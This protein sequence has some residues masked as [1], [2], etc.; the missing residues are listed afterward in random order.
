MSYA[1]L[2]KAEITKARKADSIE[3][4]ISTRHPIRKILD[5][6]GLSDKKGALERA[7]LLI[8][9]EPVTSNEQ[10]KK[11]IEAFYW[12]R[13]GLEK[14]QYNADDIYLDIKCNQEKDPAT[15][16]FELKVKEGSNL[17]KAI[18]Q[19]AL[20]E[21][22]EQPAQ[23]SDSTPVHFGETTTL[24]REQFRRACVKL[25]SK[26]QSDF[27][28]PN[29]PELHAN[30]TTPLPLSKKEVDKYFTE[31]FQHLTELENLK[32]Y[33]RSVTRQESISE[34]GSSFTYI[35]DGKHTTWNSVITDMQ[36]DSLLKMSANFGV[37]KN[38]CNQLRSQENID[39]TNNIIAQWLNFLKPPVPLASIPLLS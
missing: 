12:L 19:A 18:K 10:L 7:F 20:D 31:C 4:L 1:G 21:P 9:A 25:K 6:I 34:D 3:T 5:F 15:V 8:S 17:D 38:R 33:C 14:S 39:S 35:K 26:L 16:T 30:G 37:C 28:T 29:M 23:P 36:N 22:S 32:V 11:Q 27:P 2:C 24:T 13:D